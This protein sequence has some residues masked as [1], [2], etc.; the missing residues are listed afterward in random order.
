MWELNREV[1][2]NEEGRRREAERKG[3]EVDERGRGI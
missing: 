2:T 3:A 1:A